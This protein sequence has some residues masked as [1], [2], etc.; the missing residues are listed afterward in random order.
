MRGRCRA[1]RSARR[2]GGVRQGTYQT[3]TS[4]DSDAIAEEC[5]TVLA[6]SPLIGTS[7]QVIYGNSNFS[8]K[9]MY[10]VGPDYR[11]S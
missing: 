6:A 5:S 11:R 7:G 1:G 4:K 2:R 3:L 8:P 10:G 9:E